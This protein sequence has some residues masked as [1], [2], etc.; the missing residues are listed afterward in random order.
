MT[1]PG[2]L[3]SSP[4]YLGE[5]PKSFPSRCL[6]SYAQPDSQGSRLHAIRGETHASPHR[7]VLS[8]KVADLVEVSDVNWNRNIGGVSVVEEM[9]EVD[10]HGN[11]TNE[12]AEA[13]RLEIFHVP[14]FE[15]QRAEIFADEWH[16]AIIQI[17]C[18]K[19]R[20]GERGAERIS[21]KGESVDEVQDVGKV[22]PD[23]LFFEGGEAQGRG[24]TLLRATSVLGRLKIV[25]GELVAKPAKAVA[26]EVEVEELDG[27]SVREVD[28][29]VG[30]ETGEPGRPTLMIEGGE[31]RVE[32]GDGSV[33]VI[34]D[35]LP[36]CSVES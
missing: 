33:A 36:K 9:L 10:L 3:H 12:F 6:L 20:V 28:A 11:G 26:L 7:L 14:D 1:K 4:Q 25:L 31:E 34:F 15:H 17:Y 30:V 32:I 35:G 2:R 16:P 29:R 18:V 8:G 19:V 21:R 24:G 5:T 27:V 23:D 13:R 22:S